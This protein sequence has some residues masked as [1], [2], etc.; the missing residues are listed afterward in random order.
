M[1]P[2]KSILMLIVILASFSSSCSLRPDFSRP[3][4]PVAEQHL[5][6]NSSD[7]IKSEQGM[8]RWWE[9][10]EDPLLNKYVNEILANNLSLK[11]A[12]ERVI[13]ANERL[14]IQR[15]PLLPALSADGSARRSFTPVNSIATPSSSAANSSQRF[16]NT[17]LNAELAVSWQIDLFGRIKQSINA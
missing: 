8:N 2:Q 3:P 1:L 15:G 9:R 6:I 7:K 17:S 11:Q 10:L 14:N 12:S 13:Q 4:L 5:F 16:Y